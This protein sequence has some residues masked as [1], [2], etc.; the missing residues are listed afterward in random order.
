MAYAFDGANRLIILTPGTVT[1]DVQDMYS[2][3]KDW[4]TGSNGQNLAYGQAMR[5]VGGD[6]TVADNRIANYFYLM[7]GWKIR[8]QEASHVLNVDGTLIEETGGDPFQDTVGN[9]RVRIVQVIPM[10]AEAIVT[11]EGSGTGGL[12]DDERSL[13]FDL[14][15]IHGLIPGI[16]LVVT[17]NSRTAGG[18]SQTITESQGTVTIQRA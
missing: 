18:V 14:A 6:E 4:A 16:P 11:G 5:V 15:R 9:W 8:P 17:Q 3:W 2:R 13:L 10:Q 12:R 1:L 7:N